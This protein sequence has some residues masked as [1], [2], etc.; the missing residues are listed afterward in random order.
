MGNAVSEAWTLSGD[1]EQGN[2]PRTR[3]QC[4][5]CANYIV[6]LLNCDIPVVFEANRGLIA[7]LVRAY[8]Q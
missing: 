6:V 4:Y 5:F 1:S 7:Q 3:M 8:G 2:C